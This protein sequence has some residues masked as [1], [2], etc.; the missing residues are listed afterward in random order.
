MLWDRIRSNDTLKELLTGIAV[1]GMLVLAFILIFTKRKLY[2][3]IG[4]I[5]GLLL[6]VFY[7]INLYTTIDASLDLDEKEAAAYTRQKYLIRYVVVCVV[8][9]I[10]ALTDAGNLF[11]CFA[12]ILGIKLGAYLQP[13]VRR[14]IFRIIDPPGT[15]LEEDEPLLQ[16]TG[17]AVKESGKLSEGEREAKPPGS[18]G[19]EK[20]EAE[21]SASGDFCKG[22]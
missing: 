6:A 10:L 18:G 9:V 20:Q 2:G 19:E 4:L 17:E 7:V 1:W 21:S 8:Y 14:Y 11:T 5:V 15:A 3:T 12:G 16:E 22:E 13:F